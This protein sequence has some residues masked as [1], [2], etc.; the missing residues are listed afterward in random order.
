M[1]CL[2]ICTGFIVATS[3]YWL[4]FPLLWAGRQFENASNRAMGPR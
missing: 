3:F 4:A 2:F 1:K